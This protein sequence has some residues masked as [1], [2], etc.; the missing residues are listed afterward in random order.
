MKHLITATALSLTLVSTAIYADAGQCKT[1]QPTKEAIQLNFHANYLPNLIPALLNSEK[2]LNLTAD[3]CRSFNQLR[4]KK[5][6]EGKLLMKEIKALENESMRMALAGATI[7]EIQARHAKIA[8]LRAKIVEGKM[9]C[10]QF[11]KDH[12]NEDQYTRLTQDIY[13]KMVAKAQQKIQ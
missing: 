7:Q 12:L 1:V 8:E 11:V 9:K 13:P 6:K 4:E 3:Q 2:A 5:G 10:H